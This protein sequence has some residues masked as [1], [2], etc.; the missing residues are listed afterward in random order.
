MCKL[1]TGAAIPGTI[2]VGM[3]SEAKKE[4]ELMKGVWLSELPPWTSEFNPAG[5][6]H[7]P[8]S[9]LN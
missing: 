8:Q 9:S 2:S 5:D 3:G 1:S 4:R 7:E 6:L